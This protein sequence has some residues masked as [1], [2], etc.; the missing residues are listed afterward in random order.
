MQVIT[1]SFLLI[2]YVALNVV[3]AVN[4][5]T[6]AVAAALALAALVELS[7]VVTPFTTILS[8]LARVPLTVIV[9]TPA[10]V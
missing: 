4:A 9:Y 10:P 8:P 5:V 1:P 3:S 2:E 7:V 6:T